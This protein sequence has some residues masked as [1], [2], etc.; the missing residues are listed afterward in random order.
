[1]RETWHSRAAFLLAA[2]GSA[3]GLG[4]VWRFP[5]ICYKYGGG[6]FLIP[7]II[8]LLT[9][10]IPLMILE[11]SLGHKTRLSAPAAFASIHKNR[12]WLGWFAL[13]VAFGIVS[14][15]AVVMGWSFNYFFYSFKLNWGNATES[16]FYNNFLR[17][18]NGALEIGGVRWIIIWTLIISWILIIMCIWKG[19]HTVG[20]VVYFTA[21]VP[22]ILLIIFVIRGLTL[23]G[24]IEGLRYYLTPNFGALKNFEVWA[25][26]YGQ[27]FF[28]LSLGFGIMIAYASYLPED[29]DIVNNAMIVCFA[30]AGFAF[31]AGFVVFS[32]LGYYSY[33]KGVP[34]PEVV[35]SGPGLAFVTYP[36][37]I[38][39]L[40]FGREII[41]AL[42]FGM[43][44]T[45]AIDSAFS[46]V[47]AVIAGVADKFR[48][49][50]RSLLNILFLII[51]IGAGIIYT[52][53]AGLY[54]LDII[55]Y[56]MS[57]FGLIIVGLMEVIFCGYLFKLKIFKEHCNKVS[58]IKIGI[59]WDICIKIIIPIMLF[60]LLISELIKRLK[61]P[62][63]NYPWNV[64]IWGWLT[65]F[66]FY[67]LSIII[68]R[69]K[70]KS[71]SQ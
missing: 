54:W 41:G 37:I 33:M 70:E 46:L 58:E 60:I 57:N 38:N 35:T 50:S 49:V 1:M 23:P 16:F 27:V 68:S 13:L 20:K 39:L 2:F 7:Y 71:A 3:I 56:F 53:K 51:G 43:L 52:T 29:A 42:F 34:V 6:A 40:P 12:E 8:A 15:Y 55:D 36:T 67:L 17:L 30:D 26:A 22:I 14:Y 65:L 19:V 45:L 18:S 59:W 31:L 64:E 62:Y 32:T 48:H 25:N 4:N 69:T 28:S 44:I 24:A 5:Y 66:G 21:T 11:F 63:G 61:A 47:E 10:G 9:A